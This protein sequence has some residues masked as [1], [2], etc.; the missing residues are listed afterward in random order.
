[1]WTQSTGEVV[2]DA[3]AAIHHLIVINLPPI[4]D[5]PVNQPNN[6]QGV[7]FPMR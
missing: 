7:F 2:H 4:T 1:M 6:W 5:H 3:Y